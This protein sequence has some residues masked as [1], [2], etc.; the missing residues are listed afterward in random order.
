[1]LTALNDN[2]ILICLADYKNPH[3]LQILREKEKFS[4][5]ACK[6]KVI[7][8]IGTKKIPHF[9][10]LRDSKCHN[11]YE[12]ESDYHLLGKQKLYLWLK[13]MGLN[14]ELEAYDETIQQRPDIRFAFNQTKYAVEFQCSVI[15]EDLFRKRTTAFQQNDYTPIW[16][17]GGNQF[18]RKSA[19]VVSL[20][21]FQYL[22]L[23]SHNGVPRLPFYCPTANQFIFLK[24]IIPI[25]SRNAL[26]S[27][28]MKTPE[29][30]SLFELIS[31]PK[32]FSSPI[33]SW[34]KEMKNF[35]LYFP[36]IPQSY[37]EPFLKELYFNHL[38]LA[39]LPPE[40]G[41]PVSNSAFIRTPPI[42]WQ[43]FIFLDSF[44]NCSDGDI[45]SIYS[46]YQAF[47]KRIRKRHISL[48]TIPLGEGNA[49]LAV[50][51]Y[52][53]ML[54]GCQFLKRIS[55]TLFKMMYT[56]KPSDNMVEQ[57]K[58]EALFYE[59]LKTTIMN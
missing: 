38:H 55:D 54:V 30:A 29:D 37:R 59:K 23:A 53:Q 39:Y 50:L 40:I 9:S 34:R 27:I 1:M 41:L 18:K 13:R 22:S 56:L 8:K 42:I 35:K 58:K 49:S 5:P 26:A 12:N 2:G 44:K 36:Q 10:H 14:P 20:S 33:E 32:E 24:Q 7:L 51:E 43:G 47:N 21:D 48:R 16:I 11:H 52:L 17:L 25:T 6:E 19:N 31:P 46:I 15:S 28:K 4:C 3:S 45:I 57:E